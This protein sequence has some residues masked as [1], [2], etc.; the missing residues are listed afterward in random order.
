MFSFEIRLCHFDPKIE[1]VN[2]DNHVDWLMEYLII[3]KNSFN[4]SY[5]FYYCYDVTYVGPK[6]VVGC[7]NTNL[8]LSIWECVM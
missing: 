6:L 3:T 2:E 1:F 5:F 8:K 4:S 7:T